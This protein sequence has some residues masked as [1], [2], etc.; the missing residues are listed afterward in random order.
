[1]IVF[2]GMVFGALFGALQARRRKGNRLDMVQYA[3]AYG[4]VFGLVGFFAT[5]VIARSH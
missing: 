1:M 2:A 5:V 4:I 3:A